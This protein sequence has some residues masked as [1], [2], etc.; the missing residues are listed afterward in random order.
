MNYDE[1]GCIFMKLM[2]MIDLYIFPIA[3]DCFERCGRVFATWRSAQAVRTNRLRSKPSAFAHRVPSNS[4]LMELHPLAMFHNVIQVVTH[5]PAAS[6]S[7]VETSLPYLVIDSREIDSVEHVSVPSV[8]HPCIRSVD[9]IHPKRLVPD[10]TLLL[11]W[12]ILCLVKDRLCVRR[13]SLI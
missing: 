10:P 5:N 7:N 3:S 9:R 11:R 1:L 2:R 4:R 8:I 12:I 13:C 6:S